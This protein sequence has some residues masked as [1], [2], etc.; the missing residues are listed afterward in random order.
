MCSDR[1]TGEESLTQAA[2]FIT[3]VSIAEEIA[4]CKVYLFEFIGIVQSHITVTSD[5]A[6]AAAKTGEATATHTTTSTTAATEAGAT[7]NTTTTAG[8]KAAHRAND[9]VEGE[10][11]FVDIIGTGEQ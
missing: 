9:I 4:G 3:T 7:T 6:T 10:G 1:I 5:T 2:C 8:A 11:L